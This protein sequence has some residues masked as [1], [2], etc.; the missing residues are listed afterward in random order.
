[1]QITGKNTEELLRDY[2]IVTELFDQVERAIAVADRLT[3]GQNL[4]KD[5]NF[6]LY[7]A[8][9]SG[10]LAISPTN[11]TLSNVGTALQPILVNYE[12]TS[13]D[14]EWIAGQLSHLVNSLPK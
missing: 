13:T 4:I 1:M 6:Y 7:K 12:I 3:L 10:Y 2:P 14:V 11:K 9:G 5:G 8:D